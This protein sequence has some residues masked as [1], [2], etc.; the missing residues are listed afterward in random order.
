MRDGLLTLCYY[1]AGLSVARRAPECYGTGVPHKAEKHTKFKEGYKMKKKKIM[2][3]LLAASMTAAAM[4][5]GCSGSEQSADTA[6]GAE[7]AGEAASTQE[8]EAAS[9]TDNTLLVAIQSKTNISDYEDNYMTKT[10]EEMT[11]IDIEFVMLPAASDE[12]QTKVSLMV[13]AQEDLPDVLI[14]DSLS[15]QTVFEYGRNGIFLPVNDYVS[16]PEKMPNYN[17]IPE[18]ERQKIATILTLSDGNMYSFAKYDAETWNTTSNRLF[19]NRAWLDK[20]GLDV[21]TTTDELKEVLI[22][23]RDQDPNGNGI[24]D[25]IPLYGATA[26]GYGGNVTIGLMNSFTYYS[27]PLELDE[28]GENVIAA[29]TTE[30]FKKG[31]LYMNDL[32]NEGLLSPSIFTDDSTQFK[33]TLNQEPGVV[34]FVSSGSLSNWP[35]AATNPNFLEMEMI[36]PMTGPDGVCWSPYQASF[37]FNSHSAMYIFNGTEKADLAVKLADA[38]YDPDMSTIARYGE[39]DVD[40]TNDPEILEGKTNDYVSAG[41]YD[42]VKVALINDVWSETSTNKFWGNV[43]PRYFSTEDNDRVAQVGEY[44]ADDPANL[45]GENLQLYGGKHPEHYLPNILHYTEEEMTAIQGPMTDIPTYV[46]QSIA[47]FITGARDIE[48]GWEDY[49]SELDSLGLQQWIECAQSAYERSLE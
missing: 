32:Y 2:A 28:S 23:F 44:S 38:F 45:Y 21:P 30:G 40:W 18:E 25:E 5:A 15:E 3:L 11:G 42:S 22:A 31:L 4:L 47:E 24:Q 17:S 41:L 10:L 12:L 29:C 1:S 6:A 16:D 20:L 35:D 27:G 19:I 49:L 8:T 48:S 37:G 46:S 43:Q 26:V 7:S 34:G 36:A 9:D 39:K 13:T 14:T 33:A